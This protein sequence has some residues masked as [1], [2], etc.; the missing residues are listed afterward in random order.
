[1]DAIHG[2]SHSCQSQLSVLI[3][4]WSILRN[5]EY[6]TILMSFTCPFLWSAYIEGNVQLAFLA[7]PSIRYWIRRIYFSLLVHILHNISTNYNNHLKN[8]QKC[9]RIILKWQ[10]SDL[11]RGQK[12]ENFSLKPRKKLEIVQNYQ[13]IFIIWAKFFL[14]LSEVVAPCLQ[15]NIPFIARF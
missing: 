10:P 6:F 15:I 8:D 7:F 5:F 4:K 3:Q 13:N 11:I 1:M 12:G 2:I 14:I 9:N